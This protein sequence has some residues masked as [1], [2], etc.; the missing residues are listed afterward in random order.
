MPLKFMEVL[1]EFIEAMKLILAG[2]G[3]YTVIKLIIEGVQERR[4][5]LEWKMKHGV[6]RLFFRFER[7]RKRK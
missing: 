5:L 2:I 6:K 3:I 7:R 4:S 1:S